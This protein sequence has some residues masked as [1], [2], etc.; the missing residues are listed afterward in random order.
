MCFVQ[1]GQVLV[2]DLFHRFYITALSSGSYF[3]DYCVL[4]GIPSNFF[5][6][7]NWQ[8]SKKELLRM[9]E[10]GKSQ[11]THTMSIPRKKFNQILTDYPAF[12]VFLRQRAIIRRAFWRQ[13]ELEYEK[14]LTK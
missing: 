1:S 14:S 2:A 5:F 4:F 13:I 12:T 11:M 10:N 8:F 7:A 6:V 3:G 9:K